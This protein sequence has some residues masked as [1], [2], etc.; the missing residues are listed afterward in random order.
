MAQPSMHV[1]ADPL[2][3]FP[4][5]G[6]P[7]SESPSVSEQ[8]HTPVDKHWGLAAL[9][10]VSV[11]PVHSVQAPVRVPDVLHAGFVAS[12]QSVFELHPT[13]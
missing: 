6:L 5:V 2:Q 10:R 12:L 13:H 1:P 3:T 8:P 7:H 4:E 11:E 9:H